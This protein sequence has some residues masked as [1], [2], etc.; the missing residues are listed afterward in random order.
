M[1]RMKLIEPE[2]PGTPFF[3]ASSPYVPST[4]HRFFSLSSLLEEEDEPEESTDNWKWN[5]LK[6][7]P[8]NGWAKDT[9]T[10]LILN[11]GEGVPIQR[12]PNGPVLQLMKLLITR[13]TLSSDQQVHYLLKIMNSG[14][15]L[16][17]AMD[18]LETAR[19]IKKI[20]RY[21][22]DFMK[23]KQLSFTHAAV[24]Q[25]IDHRSSLLV[26]EFQL[27]LTYKQLDALAYQLGLLNIEPKTI[28]IDPMLCEEHPWY[29]GVLKSQYANNSLRF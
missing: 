28:E 5:P 14:E 26:S 29:Q 25:Q 19:V 22:T 24:F 1:N 2:S 9:L 20:E 15:S 10:K 3:D 6:R 4:R 18:A 16:N 23:E 17:L 11:S 27:L 13:V 7:L 21:L 8:S 12:I